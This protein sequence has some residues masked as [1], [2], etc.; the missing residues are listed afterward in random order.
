[1]EK[2]KQITQKG[3]R[4]SRNKVNGDFC[5]QHSKNETLETIE[6]TMTITIG[7]QAENHKGMQTIGQI[8]ENGFTMEELEKIQK[9]FEKKKCECEL[10]DLTGD[11]NAESA[12]ILIIRKGLEILGNTDDLFEELKNLEWDKKA[13][14]Y[15]RVV[16]K[17]ARHNLCF[18]DQ[19]QTPDY[20]DGKG[21]I[22]AFEDV[23]ELNKVM[24]KLPKFT[25][26]K[27]E[28]LVAEGN[29]YYDVR[30]TFIGLHGDSERKIVI[31]FRLG[32]TF[33][34]Y[35]QWFH[36]GEAIGDR[37]EISLDHGDIYIMSEKATGNDW[38]TRNKLT[39]R[40]AAGD[41]KHLKV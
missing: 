35:Y 25:G 38:K 12:G 39:L 31:A 4:C 22:I 7:D 1:M 36:K 20:S 9:K 40:H 15:G 37:I 29:R 5:T 33:P 16:N 24:K 21:T 2:C 30:K 19:G 27:G 13:L 26:P 14:M 34:L 23:P 3:T 41:L 11:L 10:I 6:E 28:S 8:Q 32:A 18:A 17:N